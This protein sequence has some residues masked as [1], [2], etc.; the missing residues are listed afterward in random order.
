MLEMTAQNNKN[1]L[2]CKRQ[3]QFFAKFAD[4]ERSLKVSLSFVI[5]IRNNMCKVFAENGHVAH[6]LMFFPLLFVSRQLNTIIFDHLSLSK[7]QFNLR[8][9]VRS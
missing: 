2:L 6:I 9:N 1:K 5:W 7:M 8:M 4:V 3:K